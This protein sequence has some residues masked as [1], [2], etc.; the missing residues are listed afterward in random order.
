ME[1]IKPVILMF[2]PPAGLDRAQLESALHPWAEQLA[3][4]GEESLGLPLGA[5]AGDPAFKNLA[6]AGRK[7][8]AP[9]GK[10][11]PMLIVCG[12]DDA[13]LDRILGALKQLSFRRELLVAVLTEVNRFWTADQ[14]RKELEKERARMERGG[15]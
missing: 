11:N 8:T 12:G 10:P 3:F 15:R 13:W 2:D 5:L 4:P 1:T 7:K 14:L 6:A 9:G